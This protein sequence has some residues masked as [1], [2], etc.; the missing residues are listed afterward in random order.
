MREMKAIKQ[1]SGWT[2]WGLLG[3][4]TLVAFFSLLILKLF[5]PY[6]ANF[7]LKRALEIVASEPGAI[8][9]TKRHVINRLDRILYIDY[10]H[11]IVNLKTALTIERTSS[12]RVFVINYDHIEP[13]AFNLSALIEF[14]DRVEVNKYR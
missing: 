5:P 13:L 14:E 3:A 4:M 10:A 8:N 12:G 7:K 1:Q 11:E 9:A 2:M 6:M